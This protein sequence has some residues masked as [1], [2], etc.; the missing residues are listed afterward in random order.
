MRN[1]LGTILLLVCGLGVAEPVEAAKFSGRL[2][3]ITAVESDFP[4]EVGQTDHGLLAPEQHQGLSHLI[5]VIAG[6]DS[7]AD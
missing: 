4:V 5:E 1:A 3:N 7:A 2:L 6:K